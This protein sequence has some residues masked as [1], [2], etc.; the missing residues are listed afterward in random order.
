MKKI[1][2]LTAA[3]F[4]IQAAPV[5]AEDHGDHKA[6]GKKDKM[7]AVFQETDTNG[8]GMI[9]RDEYLSH[10]QKKA[11]EKFA[12]KDTDGDGNITME[13]SKSHYQERRGEMKEKM[14]ERIEKRKEMKQNSEAE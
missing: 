14:K 11:S 13:E 6:H 3:G 10:V 7:Q 4:M 5:L 8:D 2:M 1:L 9:S 12:E